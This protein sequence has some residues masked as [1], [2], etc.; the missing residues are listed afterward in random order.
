MYE[1]S[2]VG[3]IRERL[4]EPRHHMQ[5]LRGPRQVGKTTAVLQ[6]LDGLSLW[7]H[8]ASA[9]APENQ[10]RDWIYAQWALVRARHAESG[11]P[12]V[13]ALDEVQKVA[14]WSDVVK[15]LW[16]EDAREARDIRVIMLGSSPHLVDRGLGDSLTG[17]FETLHATHWTWPECRDAFGW[18][19]ETFVYFGSYPGAATL[20]ADEARWRDYV[21]GAVIETTISRDVLHMVRVDKPAVLR[22][23]LYLGCEYSG[24]ELSLRKML[25]EL[26]DVGNATTL[27]HYLDLLAGAGLVSGLQK[28][29]GEIVRRRASAPKLQV[30]NNAL[31]SVMSPRSFDEARS[32][33]AWWGRLVESCVGAH[34]LARATASAGGVYY[35][36]DGDREV[37]YVA[38]R[39]TKVS[40]FEVKTGR[41]ARASGLAAFHDAFG[42]GMD[43]R[44]IGT[45]GES[46]QRFLET[47]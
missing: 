21:R 16:D 7:S 9:D 19:L 23:V 26:D 39:G 30:H 8:Y 11:E 1:R 31:M 28:Y 37:D 29:A 46:L 24:R 38:T 12:C 6:A 33:A 4:T 2:V 10:T 17:R 13:L 41:R 43:A 3:A 35:W 40:A 34:L 20:V 32:D 44:I 5:V 45:G 27:A 15:Q 25:G 36:R 14:R 42:G 47:W 18:D 22:R